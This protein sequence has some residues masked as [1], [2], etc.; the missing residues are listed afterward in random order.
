MVIG[1]GDLTVTERD[2]TFEV[3]VGQAFVPWDILPNE[4]PRA[5]GRSIVAQAYELGIERRWRIVA[6]VRIEIVQIEKERFI[7]I[8]GEP[9]KYAFVELIGSQLGPLPISQR[10]AIPLKCQIARLEFA[11]KVINRDVY[12]LDDCSENG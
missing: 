3:S 8:G 12:P 6:Q 11:F 10:S 4:L 5:T 7:A 1:T 2:D 9:R